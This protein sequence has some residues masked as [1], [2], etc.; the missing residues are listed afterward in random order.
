MK[1]E[2]MQ[3]KLKLKLDDLEIESFETKVAPVVTGGATGYLSCRNSSC[4]GGGP[5]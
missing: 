5:C 4:I 3:P 1:K 2:K